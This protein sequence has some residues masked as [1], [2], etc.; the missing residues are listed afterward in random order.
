MEHFNQTPRRKAEFIRPPNYLKEKVG[1]GG[2]SE[3]ILD[4]AQKLLE[5]NTVNFDPLA[6]MYLD[7][8]M[9]GIEAAKGFGPADDIE[10]VISCMLYPA[11]QLKA[12]GGMFHYNLVTQIAD[13]L[14]QFLEVLE[15]PD[16]SAVEIILAFHTTIRAVVHGKITGDGGSHGKELLSALQGACVRYFNK[17]DESHNE[18]G[19]EI[20]I[21]FAE[22]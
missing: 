15:E 18:A 21:G 7:T 2:L 10:Y 5:E 22:E 6:N 11:M 14:V 17:D 20:D 19:G 13:K 1:T 8:L 9:Q 16:I 12:N 4:K 3:D